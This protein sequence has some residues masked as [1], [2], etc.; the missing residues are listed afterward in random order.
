ME[1]LAAPG[2]KG[3]KAGGAGAGELG[4]GGGD[5]G[6]RGSDVRRNILWR[7]PQFPAGTYRDM[8]PQSQLELAK[9]NALN[10]SLLERKEKKNALNSSLLESP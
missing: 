1:N 8:G 5:R 2:G 9:K 3:G 7:A 6:S 4:A 10:S